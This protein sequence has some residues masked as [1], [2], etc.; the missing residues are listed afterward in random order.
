MTTF[1]YILLFSFAAM[2]INTTGIFVMQKNERW[3][4][5][6]KEYFMCFAAGVLITSPLIS[7]FPTAVSNNSYAGIAALL[8]FMFMF[9]VNR[10]IKS[11]T[12]QQELTFC[13][14]ALL[15]IAIHSFVDG[16]IY[17]VTFH[18]STIFGV[19][20]GIGL[21]AHE[22]AEGVITYSILLKSGVHKNKA[23][24]YAFLVAALT[25]PI[26]A[27]VAYPL[28]STLNQSTLGLAMG[29]VSGVMIYLSA[30]HLLPSVKSEEKHHSYLAFGFG[31][32]LAFAFFFM[33]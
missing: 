32:L 18:V 28:I 16:A 3:T 7:A 15:G 12:N 27:L 24:F 22:F 6:N 31:V 8:G 13:I 9:S 20:S 23:F 4:L 19:A 26:G 33:K 11:K 14:T 30:S 29:A 2:I 25:T 1:L 10:L 17:S 21:V 5:K